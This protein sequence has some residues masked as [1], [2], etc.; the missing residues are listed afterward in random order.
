MV[1]KIAFALGFFMCVAASKILMTISLC[2]MATA[3]YDYGSES[4]DR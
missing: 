2:V 3:V 4:I 1:G